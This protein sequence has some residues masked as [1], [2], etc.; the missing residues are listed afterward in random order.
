MKTAPTIID[1]LANLQKVT[2]AG[3]LRTIVGNSMLALVRKELSESTA[4]ALGDLGKS[5]SMLMSAECKMMKTK[6]ELRNLGEDV[7][8]IAAMGN[9][10][11]GNDPA[12]S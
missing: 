10:I 5:M 6:V 9:T 8:R 12:Q 4:L 11:I 7:G 3:D 1:S 2:T